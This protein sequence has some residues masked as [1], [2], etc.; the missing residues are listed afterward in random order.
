MLNIH[1]VLL[2]VLS[3][4]YVMR[5]QISR[6]CAPG[7]LVGGPRVYQDQFRGFESHRVHARW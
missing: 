1:R 7:G 4:F 3:S 5:V 2:I 6:E